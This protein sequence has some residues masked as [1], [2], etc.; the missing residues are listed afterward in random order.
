MGARACDTPVRTAAD[1]PQDVSCRICRKYGCAAIKP[2]NSCSVASVEPSLTYTISNVRPFKLPCS[3]A[4]IS[5]ISGAI[6]P[7]SLR[8]GTTTEIAGGASR[9][10]LCNMAQASKAHPAPVQSHADLP[11]STALPAPNIASCSAAL[12]SFHDGPG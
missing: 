3:A 6:L 8:T 2:R 12:T 7:A 4:A 10:L 9:P 5:V 1:C 11:G